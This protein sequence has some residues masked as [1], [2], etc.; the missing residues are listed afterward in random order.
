MA[1]FTET[2]YPA[3]SAEGQ[4]G[5]LPMPE[6]EGPAVIV[7]SIGAQCGKCFYAPGAFATLANVQVIFPDAGEAKA[8]YLWNL[9]NAESFWPRAQTAQPFIRPSDIKKA[10]VVLPPEREMR[11]VSHLFAAV[12]EAIARTRDELQAAR[13]LKTALMQHLFTR[14]L[15]GRHTCL[16]TTKRLTAPATWQVVRLEQLAGIRS[17]F[18][19][20]RDLAGYERVTLPYLTVVNV[21]E[22]YFDLAE[23]STAEVKSSE[24]EAVTLRPG[25]VL[26]TEGG[27]RDKLGRGGI[28][29]GQIEPCA[30]QNHIFRIR[31]RDETYSARLF[32]F[33]LQAQGTKRYFFA[34]AK[35]TSNLCTINSRELHRFPV[36]VP[37]PD[38]Q[39]EM[40]QVL[41]SSETA[42]RSLQQ[43]DLALASIKT[44]LLQN[45]LTGKVRV[46]PEALS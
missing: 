45:L 39:A 16:S 20:G 4:V 13:R 37:D 17:G 34:H 30:Y 33:L 15:P 10:W 11:D 7:S 38:E 6:F 29:E 25:D 23:I 12:D 32:H 26:V 21:Q 46:R 19:M 8:Y 1:D 42:I 43:L 31:F 35:Q 44:S 18:T 40:L 41:E 28:W 14:G 2:G 5:L 27:D 36:A 22:G 3:F 9:L 24:L